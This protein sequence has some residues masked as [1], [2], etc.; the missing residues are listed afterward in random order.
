ME[1]FR[2][3]AQR[4]AK[5]FRAHRHDHEFLDVDRGV[6]VRTT[7]HDVHHRHRQHLGIRAANVFVKGQAQRVRRRMGSCERH[8]QNG[9]RTQLRL[10][11]RAIELEHRRVNAQLVHGVATC[12]HWRDDVVHVVHRRQHAL[13]IVALTVGPLGLA[14]GRYVAVAQFQRL[15]LAG[16]RARGHGR[17]AKAAAGQFHVYLKGGIAAGVNDFASVDV[18]NFSHGGPEVEEGREVVNRAG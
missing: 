8:T 12:Q 17:T 7:V 9:I 1:N 16:A 11:L 15:V 3:H 4:L 13:A 6:R 2:A 14:L 10:V 5:G 18:D